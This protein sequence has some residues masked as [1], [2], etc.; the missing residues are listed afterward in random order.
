MGTAGVAK[1]IVPR[2]LYLQLILYNFYLITGLP[3]FF[4]VLSSGFQLQPAAC[5]V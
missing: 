3:V 5:A 2:Y 4:A 1:L